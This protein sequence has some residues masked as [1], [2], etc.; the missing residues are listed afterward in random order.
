[1]KTSTFV[2][3]CIFVLAAPAR[4]LGQNLEDLDLFAHYTLINTAED[5]LGLRN[6]MLLVNTIYEDQDGIY[7]NGVHPLQ[8]GGSYARTYYMA[9]LTDSKFAF[10]LEFKIEDLDGQYRCVVACGL[11]SLYLGLFIDPSEMFRFLLDNDTYIEVPE[12][13]PEE[14]VWYEFTMIYDT[15]TTHAQFYLDGLQLANFDMAPDH[16]QG[17]AFIT[18]YNLSSGGSP[19]NGN[20][21]NLRVFGKEDVSALEEELQSSSRLKVFPNPSNDHL[22]FTYSGRH[23]SQWR[24][25][26][27]TGEI[28]LAGAVTDHKGTIHIQELPTGVYVL[29]ILDQA[30][31]PLFNSRFVHG[32]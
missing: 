14:E 13:T 22:A 18:N 12:F 17:D 29:Y 19:L 21:R 11:S 7:C 25:S 8:P 16:V 2:L 26:K 5:A 27:L 23:A 15:V 32:K 24:V 20:W 6:D 9:A 10:Q 28:M 3:S 30:G 4:S 1:M 31:H